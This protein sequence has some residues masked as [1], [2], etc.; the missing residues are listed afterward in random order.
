M[1]LSLSTLTL[2]KKYTED[3][4]MQF[5]AVKGA[6]CKIKTITPS[7]DGTYNTVT[8]EWKNDEVQ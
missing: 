2:S 4:A 3:T 1:A 7:D 8:F 5:G 6:N